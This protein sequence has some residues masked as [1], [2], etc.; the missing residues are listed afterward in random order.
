MTGKNATYTVHLVACS[1]T[2]SSWTNFQD[3]E[4]LKMNTTLDSDTSK[5]QQKHHR[6]VNHRSS[7]EASRH[8]YRIG[9]VLDNI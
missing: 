9:R 1:N 3:G 7:R 8:M 6:I 5:E 4:P 2:D